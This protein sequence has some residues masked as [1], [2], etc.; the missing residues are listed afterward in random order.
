MFKLAR[1]SKVVIYQSIG[2]LS[3]I[4]VCLFDELVGLSA[5]ILGNQ[6]VISDFRQSILKVLLIFGVWLLV[7]GSTRRVLEHMRYLEAFMKVCAW[8]RRIEHKGRWMPMEEFFET[9]FDTPTS[10][11]I[12]RE[13]LIKTKEAI[14]RAKLE[15]VEKC[16][17]E[18]HGEE[19]PSM[20]PVEEKVSCQ[21][22]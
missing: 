12:C 22:S 6:S 2:F 10:H 14:D 18:D 3:I 11:G 16:D 1:P 15:K 9:G 19:L 5:L 21:G 13:C 7:A 4:G 20:E 8:C 17:H